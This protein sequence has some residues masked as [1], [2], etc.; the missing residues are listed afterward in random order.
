M[1]GC[2]YA[3][4]HRT[5]Y[6]NIPFLAIASPQIIHQRDRYGFDAD[7]EALLNNQDKR[8]ATVAAPK[9][10]SAIIASRGIAVATFVRTLLA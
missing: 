8:F 2:A 7:L 5:N 10:N 4:Q 6:C 1:A 9:E 3:H